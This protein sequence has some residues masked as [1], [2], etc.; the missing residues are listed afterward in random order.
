M[1]ITKGY[2]WHA[3]TALLFYGAL[4]LVVHAATTGTLR[5][6]AD[7]TND[8]ASWQNESG[9]G[10]NTANCALSVDE[11]AGA[12]CTNADGNTSYARSNTAGASQTFD[13]DESSIPDGSTITQ[14]AVTGCYARNTGT[15]SIQFRYCNNG[16]CVN[17]G[18]NLSAG[19]AY[20]ESTQNFSVSIT[21]S[22]G[23]DLEIG[24]TDTGSQRVRLSQISAVVTYTPPDTTAPSA[25]A[26]LA[27]GATG[28]STIALTWTA[29]GDDAG[30]G[31]ATSYDL[32][33]STSPITSGNFASATT[34]AGEPTPQ[35]AGTSQGMTVSG[36]SS[37]TTYYF[38]IETS[39][40]VPNIS[41]ISNVPSTTTTALPDTTAPS[42]IA[43]LATGAVGTSTIAL[44]WTA[45]G[46]DVG[47][48]TATTYDLRYSTSPITSGNFSSATTVT[49]EPAPQV[50]GTSQGM[51]VSGLSSNTT[52]YFAIKTSDEVPNTSAISNVPSASTSALPD[53]TAPA[54]VNNLAI[55]ATGTSTIGITWTAPGDDGNTGTATSYDIRY[56]TSLI[57]EGN[58]SIA[59][60]VTGEP[61]PQVAG[62]SESMTLTGLSPNTTYFIAMKTADEVPNSSGISNNDS[63]STSG[64]PDTTA[65]SAISD[66]GTG[67]VTPTTIVLTWTA[68][69]DDGGTGTATTY[70]LRYSTSPITSGNFSSATT[71][72]GEPTPQSAGSS[73]T[74]TITGLSPVTTYYFAIKT[75]DEVPNTSAIS[76]VPSATTLATL[77]STAPASITDLGAGSPTSFSIDL[78]WTAPGDDGSTGT[79]TTYDLRYSTSPITSGNFAL[80]TPVT[81]VPTPQSA[82]SSQGMTVG[83]LSALTT[84]YFAIKTSD[85]VPN[86]SAISNVPSASTLAGP[87]LV[88]PE[89]ITDLAVGTTTTSSITVSWTA[90]GDDG[91]TGTATAYDLR[92]STGPITS[93]TFSAATQVTG[94][95]IPQSAGTHQS[96]TISGLSAATPYYFAIVASDEVPNT[97]SLSNVPSG[98]TA[99]E[100]GSGSGEGTVSITTIDNGGPT[101]S[102]ALF[103]GFAFPGAVISI[104]RKQVVDAAYEG[105]SLAD[106]HVDT[107]GFF[108]AHLGYFEQA[109]YLFALKV[110][111]KEGRDART[112]TFAQFVPTGSL[113][114]IRDIVVSPTLELGKSAIAQ[115]KNLDVK[116][117]GV[118]GGKIELRIG[119]T[120]AVATTTTD[121]GQYLFTV[122]TSA[123]PV[124]TYP[125]TVRQTTAHGRTSDWSPAKTLR[126]SPVALVETDLNGDDSV[127]VKDWSI[128]LYRW[129][130]K[131]EKIKK[132]LDF[133]QDGIVSVV[134]F[135]LFMKN[136]VLR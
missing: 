76:N 54:A 80:A 124:G 61:T 49:G 133:N 108:T 111:D 88:A 115:G 87:D 106:V 68:P 58:W 19:A 83:S 28:T 21:K 114:K 36:L 123:L 46:D 86:T 113:I 35:I 45:P 101:P 134:D 93:S 119:D 13:L 38:A 75:S 118:T 132:T 6:I 65:P 15:G 9:T 72:T 135:S 99:G 51:T 131:D 103:S 107:A 125:I 22:A 57:T 126:I 56:S 96:M 40:E 30:V 92:Y 82:G 39:D 34:V 59:T 110:K 89:A 43:N 112:L 117:Y 44:T 29:P 47:T 7:G 127:N 63:G 1:S 20:V 4:F 27:T 73:E 18:T 81:G 120:L 122:D 12:S 17:S 105:T 78:T 77:D 33:Y 97:S 42:A 23:T 14:I 84:Y 136:I 11:S 32:R 52:Y 130:T 98:M 55:S 26:N 85:E 91:S 66:L 116:G 109:N 100:A 70:D 3:L 5:P 74:M 128:F 25:I 41:T 69:G 121:T 10:C 79:A 48:G 53:T 104:L 2:P 67:T 24:A 95:P 37:N 129:G 31:T 60:Q 64:L 62:S 16:T 71:V 50:A 90:P 94:E 102:E 8:T